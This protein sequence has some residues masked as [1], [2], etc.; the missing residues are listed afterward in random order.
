M[1]RPHEA[2]RRFVQ[3]L[4]EWLRSQV[5]VV[6]SPLIGIQPVAADPDLA[7]A[8]GVVF[9]SSSAVTVASELTPR[10]DLP[11]FCVG[12]ATTAR[13]R[14]AGWRAAFAG[15][16]ADA[17]VATLTRDRPETPLLHLRGRHTRGAVAARL[18]AA[19]L[20]VRESVIYDQPVLP[21]N[22]AAADALGGPAP[23]IVPLFSP[24][25][26]RQFASQHAGTAPLYLAAISNAVAEEVN[27]LKVKE[28]MVA[29]QP[30]AAAMAGLVETLSRHTARVETGKGAQ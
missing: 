15:A 11:C 18:T 13:A 12:N 19:G 1:T 14:D 17:L 29:P 25:S 21:L 5:N 3:R 4:P 20:P 28:L 8:R 10:R 7:D 16:D 24:R 2:S 9:T 30:D 26:A 22:R 27:Q 6:I 23:V